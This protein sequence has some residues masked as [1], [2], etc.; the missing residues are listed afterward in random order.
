VSGADLEQAR[1]LR[2]AIRA[3]LEAHAGEAPVPEAVAQ[4]NAIARR[5]G[6]APVLTTPS[7]SRLEPRASRGV[8]TALGKVVAAIHAAIAE[9]TWD[10][11]KAC[12]RHACRWAFY[13]HSRNRGGRWCSM[14]VCGS[15]E[16]SR[17][18][19]RRRRAGA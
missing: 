3:L 15:R 13:D 11:L 2:E 9:G 7:E 1:A 4:V 19:Y 10:R 14:A 16:K 17:R 8:D 6:L 5:A 18:A 12:E